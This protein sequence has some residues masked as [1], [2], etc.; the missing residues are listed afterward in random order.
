MILSELHK[1]SLTKE[2]IKMNNSYEYDEK[3]GVYILHEEPSPKPIG[4]LTILPFEWK[5]FLI[6][7]I[8]LIIGIAFF[9]FPVTYAG[10]STVPFDIVVSYIRGNFTE[11]VAVYVLIS[12]L[13]SAFFSTIAF[14]NKKREQKLLDSSFTS[15]YETNFS[16]W[17]LRIL[18]A[19][20][21]IM[22]F[23]GIG[24]SELHRPDIGGLMWTVLTFSVAIIIPIGAVFLSLFILLGG[25]EFVGT[26][27]RPLMRPL[28]KVPGRAALDA[29]ASWVGSY[30]VGMYVTNLVYRR[31]GYT[32]RHVF[33]NATC[34]ATVSIG[35]V[36]VVAA[37]LDLLHLFPHIFVSYFICIV[38]TAVITSRIPPLS[39]VPDHYV[40]IPDP[41]KPITGSV[42]DYLRYSIS[43]A[44]RKVKEEVGFFKIAG[45]GFIDGLKLASLIIG[46]ILA[47]GTIA[48]LI[49]EFTP[50][51]Q[52][53]G[54]PMI[55]L[56]RLFGV[57][58]ADILGPATLIGITEMFLPALLSVEASLP[59]RFF[60]AV[61]SISQ[62]I[63][64]SAVGPMMMD[65]F[66]DIPIRFHDLVILFILRTLIQIPIIAVIMHIM[67]AVGV[68]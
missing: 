53:L 45:R 67:I 12:I 48:L 50:I 55:P 56:L 31:G 10:R 22:M 25:L 33:I 3:N 42:G 46:T 4:E 18:G 32:K 58:D 5:P 49:A 64:F 20:L 19:V 68:L 21:A 29:L 34:F 26:L 36:G 61:L 43:E 6:F 54:Y 17:L 44:I 1:K 57:P 7:L 39:R 40:V 27:A 59:A 37:T 35:F 2:E 16:F 24:P 15:Y 38:L 60:I 11:A 14:I 62:L 8:S 23:T 51:F 13:V 41:E 30:S 9:I 66:K 63:F 65:M 28:F 52:W 47:V